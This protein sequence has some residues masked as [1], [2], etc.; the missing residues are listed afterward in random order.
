MFAGG[1]AGNKGWELTVRDVARPGQRCTAAVMLYSAD[2]HPIA[3]AYPISPRPTLRTP[4][5]DLAFVALGAQSPG[6]GVGFL[7]LGAPA[8]QAWVDPDRIGGLVISGPILTMHACGKRYYL[9]GFVYPLAGTLD[10]FVMSN[11]TSPLH[12][13]V[14]TRLSRPRVP[15]VWE[16]T[17]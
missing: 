14:P 13:L 3:P 10:V 12:Y 11:S 2:A 17:G 4:V 9:V 6:A 5:G 1:V 15:R 8:A 16:S 7:Q